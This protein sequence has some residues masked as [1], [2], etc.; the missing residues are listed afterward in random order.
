MNAATPAGSVHSD[1][2]VRVVGLAGHSNG[3]GTVWTCVM[4]DTTCC[5][6]RGQS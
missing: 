2:G 5:Q 6:L 3:W 4:M 1:A